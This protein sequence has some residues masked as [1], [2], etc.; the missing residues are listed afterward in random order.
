MVQLIYGPKGSGKTKRL[1]DMANADGEASKGD[2][3]FIDDNKRYIYDVK[4]PVRF[5]DVCEHEINTDERLYGFICGMLAQNFD[6]T[7]IYLDAFLHI[8]GKKPSE[9]EKLISDLKSLSEKNGVK[10]VMNVSGRLEDVPA[11][12]KDLII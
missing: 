5:V 3:V 12:L 8:I 7:A 2:V 6:I 1:I 4:R 10:L 9:T 11:F